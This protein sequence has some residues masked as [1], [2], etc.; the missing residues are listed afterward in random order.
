MPAISSI[1]KEK[2]STNLLNAL[3]EI[4]G[5]GENIE[6]IKQVHENVLNAAL[7]LINDPSETAA[8]SYKSQLDLVTL[9][10]PKLEDSKN[11]AK[12]TKIFTS[13]LSGPQNQE[14]REYFEV[15]LLKELHK[16][17]QKEI[18]TEVQDIHYQNLINKNKYENEKKAVEDILRDRK[19]AQQTEF[20]GNNKKQTGVSAGYIAKEAETGKTFILKQFNKTYIDC[21]NIKLTPEDKEKAQ[22][23]KL[24]PEVKKDINCK[25]SDLI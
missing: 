2:L 19:V 17:Q 8:N 11:L 24:T 20:T 22:N 5:S 6:K 9:K 10:I 14:L 16:K 21:L 15:P 13:A 12:I 4:D 3:T 23:I 18:F 7:D 1:D 25:L